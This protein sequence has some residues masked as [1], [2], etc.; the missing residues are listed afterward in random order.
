L[1][2]AAVVFF[3]LAL[4]SGSTSTALLVLGPMATFALPG[5]AMVAFWWNDWPQSRPPR[6]GPALSTPC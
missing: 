4:G 2:L 3:A 5:V 1:Q 6:P